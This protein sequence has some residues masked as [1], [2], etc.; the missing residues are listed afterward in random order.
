MRYNE[1][2]QHESKATKG[3]K[4]SVDITMGF[5]YIVIAVYCFIFPAV[6]DQFGKIDFQWVLGLFCLYGIFRIYRGV[7]GFKKMTIRT[8]REPSN[9]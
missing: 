7:V 9:R 4:A 3:F 5:L 8:R 2:E 1:E 6:L